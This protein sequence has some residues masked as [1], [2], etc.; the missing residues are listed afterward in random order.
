MQSVDM[1]NTIKRVFFNP[2]ETLNLA[3]G[4]KKYYGLFDKYK[5]CSIFTALLTPAIQN[6]LNKGQLTL[7][8]LTIDRPT[9]P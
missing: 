1:K 2:K 4:R 7:A 3:A 8:C 5:N 6:P 9:N